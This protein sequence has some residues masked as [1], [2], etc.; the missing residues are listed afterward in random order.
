[1]VGG[2]YL[3]DEADNSHRKK[4]MVHDGN[5]S[6]PGKTPGVLHKAGGKVAAIQG[7]TLQ[8]QKQHNHHLCKSKGRKEQGSTWP[9]KLIT[10]TGSRDLCSWATTKGNAKRQTRSIKHDATNVGYIAG[11]AAFQPPSPHISPSL[12]PILFTFPR[13]PCLTLS[14][15]FYH[16]HAF[17]HRFSNL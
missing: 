15:S 2:A 3:A 17:K 6:W 10:A 12:A 9:T 8:K 16:R 4:G 11:M 14:L 13:L 1:M 7:W 5:D